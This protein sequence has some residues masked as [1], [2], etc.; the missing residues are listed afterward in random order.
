M[1]YPESICV[2]FETAKALKEAGFPQGDVV[3]RYDNL[4]NLICPSLDSTWGITDPVW[5]T[6]A[7]TLEELWRAIRIPVIIGKGTDGSCC[8]ISGSFGDNNNELV[9]PGLARLYR[10]LSNAGLLPDKIEQ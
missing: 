9:L 1:I 8:I 4:E 5:L 3:F 6:A 10:Q 7:P 2:D